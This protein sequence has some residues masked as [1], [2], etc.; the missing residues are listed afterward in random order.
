MPLC[1]HI[2]KTDRT[3]HKRQNLACCLKESVTFRCCL[4]TKCVRNQIKF[5]VCPQNRRK[6]VSTKHCCWV[7]AKRIQ[8]I[9]RNGL[10][11]SRSRGISLQ[12]IEKCRRRWIVACSRQFFT[13][14]NITRNT[15][16]C[17]LHWPGEKGPL[18]ANFS[19]AQAS[20]VSLKRK[21]PLSREEPLIPAKREK[22]VNEQ[23]LSE[24]LSDFNPLNDKLEDN[25]T[26]LPVYESPVTG[27][28]VLDEGTQ[29]VFTKYILSAKVE[30]IISKN[31]ASTVKDQKSKIVS[32]LSFVVIR[33][34]PGLMKHF[35]GLTPSQLEVLC[36]FLND[37]CPMEKINHWNFGESVN[38]TK[39]INGLE[40]QFTPREKLFICLVR[41][42]RGFTLKTLAALLSS[43]DRKIE[44]TLVRKIFTIFIQLLIKIFR[45]M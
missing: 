6:M 35:V 1:A 33:E 44:Q 11:L 23:D 31:E 32:S 9:E 43:P 12:D 13:K 8:G 22:I 3:P 10:N 41:L 36:S 24:E 26:T 30:K 14:A 4:Q 27:K 7:S 21:A 15:Y 20:R 18:K 40:S 5:D 34:D 16:I 37:V 25:A 45:D 17:A 39:S 2:L 19:P 42:R 38:A 29:T 28:I